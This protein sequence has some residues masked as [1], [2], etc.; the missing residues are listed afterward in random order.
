M[1]F[2]SLIFK[3]FF[4]YLGRIVFLFYWLFS[5]VYNFL[6]YYFYLLLF[7][8]LF[9]SNF[10][11]S[12]ILYFSSTVTQLLM[13]YSTLYFSSSFKSCFLGFNFVRTCNFPCYSFT[14]VPILVFAWDIL[15]NILNND[16]KCFAEVSWFTSCL[17]EG[18]P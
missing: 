13:S 10:L 6:I 17:D 18:L 4:W 15:L 9:S 8:Q 11:M 7:N 5:F 2:F 1:W 16:I 12:N 14:L 3:N